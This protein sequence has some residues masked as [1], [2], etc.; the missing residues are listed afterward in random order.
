MQK[1]SRWKSF[2][3]EWHQKKLQIGCLLLSWTKKFV[4][5][6]GLLFHILNF[7][8]WRWHGTQWHGVVLFLGCLFHQLFWIYGYP[9]WIVSGLIGCVW[10]RNSQ[11]VYLTYFNN[12]IISFHFF[13]KS[14]QKVTISPSTSGFMG[15]LGLGF[16]DLWVQIFANFRSYG[17]Q[18]FKFSGFIGCG[19]RYWM[20]QPRITEY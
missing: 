10:S 18:F 20:A 16:L 5:K 7:F 9:F 3:K 14:H 1:S 19:T 15:V 8:S 6:T 2:T 13:V 4:P 17:R 12:G 11:I